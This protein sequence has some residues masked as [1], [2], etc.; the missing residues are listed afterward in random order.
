[1]NDS[2]KRIKKIS[3]FKITN[4]VV[5]TSF[6][7]A[8]SI[9]VSGL[10]SCSSAMPSAE[11]TVTETAITTVET[12]TEVTT[13]VTT[14]TA[15]S[16]TTAETLP[17]TTVEQ[18]SGLGTASELSGKI[19]I[20]S[21]FASDTVGDWEPRENWDVIRR[22][23]VIEDRLPTAVKWIEE[24]AASYGRYVE[25][26]YDYNEHEDLVYDVDLSFDALETA[27]E[28]YYAPFYETI[29]ENIPTDELLEKY[30]ADGIIYMFYLNSEP[31]VDLDGNS[32][33]V[34][35]SCARP[36]Y[37]VSDYEFCLINMNDNASSLTEP[38]AFAHEI[39]HLFGA[40][41]LYYGDYG[42]YPEIGITQD[43]ADYLGTVMSTDIMYC[44]WMYKDYYEINYTIDDLTAYYLGLTDYSE[45]V[46]E[47]GFGSSEHE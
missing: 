30:D 47:W 1:M 4:A 15:E 2:N 5:R 38:S 26:I 41:D 16:E 8:L 44:S 21:M 23:S 13:E 27:Y 7:V 39:L 19:I 14:T 3:G 36:Y 10:A 22:D 6:V 18:G 17:L 20:V 28:P 46:E 9:V 11:P 33:D 34:R 31:S 35:R 25:F 12:T 29:D 42:V 40:P 37:G 32:I 43:Y 24:Q 45:T